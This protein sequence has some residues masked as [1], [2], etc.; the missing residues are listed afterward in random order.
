MQE[1]AAVPFFVLLPQEWSLAPDLF[2]QA[3]QSGNVAVRINCLI[4]LQEFTVDDTLKIEE[5]RAHGLG[6]C[7]QAHSLLGGGA[8]P[9]P[10]RQQTG[11]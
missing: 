8:L 4:S 11:V 3:T 10:P 2:L 5:H 9:L 6:L 7:P 1:K